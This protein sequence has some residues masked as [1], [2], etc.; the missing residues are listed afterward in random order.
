[1]MMQFCVDP[2]LLLFN[3]NIVIIGAD[4]CIMSVMRYAQDRYFGYFNDVESI[5]VT[6]SL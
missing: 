3:K 2:R 4:R 5:F 1:M 6:T